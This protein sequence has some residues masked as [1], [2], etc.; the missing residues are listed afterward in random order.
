M[1]E[2]DPILQSIAVLNPV[3]NEIDLPSGAMDGTALLDRIDG[4][5]TVLDTKET[6]SKPA[7]RR[8]WNELST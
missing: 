4:R 8:R 7:P 6:Q 3:P 2:H 5:E 1:N